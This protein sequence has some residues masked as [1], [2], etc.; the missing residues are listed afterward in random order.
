MLLKKISLAEKELL[1]KRRVDL[2][3]ASVTQITMCKRVFSLSFILTVT[4]E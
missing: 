3:S 2:R 1:A 4:I